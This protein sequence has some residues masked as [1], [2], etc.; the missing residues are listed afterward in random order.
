MNEKKYLVLLAAVAAVI[1]LT[2]YSGQNLK[3]PGGSPAGYT[4]SPFDGKDCSISGCHGGSATT[5]TGW[6]T[7]NIPAGGYTPGSTYNITVTVTGSGNHGFEVS[8]QSPSGTLLGT[9]ISGTGSK[10]TGSGKYVTQSY[11]QS[12]NP[13]S[14]V[15]QWI[16]PVAGTGDVTFYGAFCVKKNTTKLSTLVVGESLA[17]LTVVASAIPSTVCAGQTA[18]LNAAVTG[19]SGSYTY[20]WTSIPS[21]FTS[22][23]QNPTAIPSLTTNY[24][25]AVNDGISNTND[26]VQVNAVPVP[27]VNAGN[28]TVYCTTISQIPLQGTAYSYSTVSWSSSGLGTF[29][30]PNALSTAYLPAT[31]DKTNGFVNL[32]LTADPLSPCSGT[33][34]DSRHIQFDPC[35]GVPDADAGSAMIYPNPSNGHFTISC[36]GNQNSGLSVSVFDITGKIIFS[37]SMN[38]GNG[39]YQK[40]IDLSA[41][42]KGIYLLKYVIQGKVSTLKLFI[43]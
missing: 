28:D 34:I 6:I 35:S 11:S 5:A 29:V 26:F 2:G 3:Y 4:G 38:T 24:Y 37:E 43:Q 15:F 13:Q 18:Q 30:D 12:G 31:E 41:F 40:A 17:P 33:A 21:G 27:T 32:Y 20:S 9:L 42:P 25:V 39:S 8:P 22:T 10:L 1:F 23:L 19:G 36:S 14:W 16:A 7:S